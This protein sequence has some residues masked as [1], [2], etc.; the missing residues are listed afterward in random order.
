[1]LPYVAYLDGLLAHRAFT[2]TGIST[3]LADPGLSGVLVVHHGAGV[4]IVISGAPQAQWPAI[5]AE[6]R[7]TTYADYQERDL[8][9]LYNAVTTLTGAQLAAVNN[10][11]IVGWP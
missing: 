1:M 6:T 7:A 2:F 3:T 5:D 9:D 8:W 10:D 4:W 11:L